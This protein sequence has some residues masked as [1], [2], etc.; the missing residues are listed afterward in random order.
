[1]RAIG[2]GVT[3]MRGRGGT[4]QPV[5]AT[6]D[7]KRGRKRGGRI[8]VSLQLAVMVAVLALSAGPGWAVH[9]LN[10]LKLDGTATGTPVDWND[11]NP[12]VGGGRFRRW[13][14]R[15]RRRGCSCRSV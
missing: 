15:G 13:R 5:E 10:L 2:Q 4:S 7:G 11:I 3:G 12:P 9:D 14:N 6:M 1:M 8:G